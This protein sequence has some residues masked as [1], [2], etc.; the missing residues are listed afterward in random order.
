MDIQDLTGL[1]KP[2]K[3]LISVVADGVGAL[4]KPYF[5]RKNADARA[6]EINV[7]A[8]AVRDN[9]KELK[10]IDYSSDNIAM[11]ALS[12]PLI[13]AELDINARAKNR[14]EYQEQK[15]QRNIED[16][17]QKAANQ[18]RSEA[19]VSDEPVNE[20]WTTRFFDYAQDVSDEE[21]QN[22][23]AQILAG[24]VK[25]P[26]SYSLRT[27]ELL[28]S[29]RKEE[30]EAFTKFAK[31]RITAGE[32][33]FIY[34]PD[35]GSYLKENLGIEFTDRL[36]LS[37]L[38]L[39]STE[40][41]LEWSIDATKDT[42]IDFI[43]HYGNKSIILNRKPNTPK[44]ALRVLLFTNIGKELAQLVDLEFNENYMNKICSTFVHPNV[45]IKYGT[46][47]FIND[48]TINLINSVEYKNN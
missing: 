18:L 5:I 26:K 1:S 3:K 17:T 48:R 6:Y 30:A 45:E 24:E 16:I 14:I 37:E 12:V 15:R 2:L 39:I 47:L 11:Q 10:A 44:Q 7:I 8:Q 21:M 4:T 38:G 36:L 32:N 46:L 29:L 40:N 22:L 19:D 23:W 28:R 31:H 33:C 27:L 43:L 42:A 9:Q 20:D 41:E 13:Q 34:N 35:K 25:K